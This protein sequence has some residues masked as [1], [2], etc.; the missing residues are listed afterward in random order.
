MGKLVRDHIP[1]IILHDGKYCETHILDPETYRVELKRKLM[2]ESLEVFEADDQHLLEELA[3]VLEV[4]E[5]IIQTYQIDL[6]E[7]NRIKESKKAKNGSFMDRIYLD[8]IEK[9]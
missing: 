3:D 6:L 1:E 5:C 8:K 2:E 7:M 9:G 4:I